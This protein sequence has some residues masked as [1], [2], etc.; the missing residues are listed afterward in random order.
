MV[1]EVN[2]MGHIFCHNMKKKFL[3]L[4]KYSESKP[5]A[6]IKFLTSKYIVSGYKTKL[7]LGYSQPK[8]EEVSSGDSLK[9]GN[10]PM[11]EINSL[12]SMMDRVLN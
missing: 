5:Q 4:Q 10:I 3:L 11:K 9:K 1:K 6:E 7:I 8:M 2:L 12:T